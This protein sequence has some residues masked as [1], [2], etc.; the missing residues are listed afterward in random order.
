MVRSLKAFDL[1]GKHVL[2]RVDFNV[3]LKDEQVVD[4]FRI[5]AALPTINY[6]LDEGAALVLMSHL[7]RPNGLSQPVFSLMPAGEELAGLLEMPIKFSHDCISSDA[8]DTSLGLKPGEIHLLENL[9]F[10]KQEKQNDSQFSRRLARHGSVYINDAFGTSHR[11]HASNVGVAEHFKHRGMGFLIEKEIKFM[12]KIMRKPSRPLL[13]ILGGAKIDSKLALIETFL[14]KADT[15]LIGGGMSFTFLKA[16]GKEVGGSLVD[17]TMLSAAK[18][19][20]NKARTKG[21]KLVL[22][23]DVICGQALDDT[24]PKG[25]FKVSSIPG[26]L[27][28]L[29]IGPGTIKKF[30]SELNAS[31]TVIWNGP[32][33]VFELQGYHVGSFKIAN[34]L[35]EFKN[36]GKTVIVGGGDTAAV[37][38]KFNLTEKMS[39][40]STGGGASLEL[41]SG[42]RLPALESLEA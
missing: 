6:A 35:A 32:L 29:D 30:M 26:E 41:L 11:S 42:K 7:G 9:R 34:H 22:P 40:V 5:Q 24:S 28:G 18:N 1:K 16:R 17:E 31:R 33:G 15:I 39:H 8:L 38:N 19:I 2:V 14:E 12:D 13:L 4:N 21:V 37:I 3:P 36:A 23:D 27:M 20:I 10:Y 25:P